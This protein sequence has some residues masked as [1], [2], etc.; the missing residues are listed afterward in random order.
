M[1]L[2]TFRLNFLIDV[3]IKTFPGKNT[4]TW[5]DILLCKYN[6]KSPIDTMETVC[7]HFCCTTK[8]TKSPKTQKRIP[9]TSLYKIYINI[10]IQPHIFSNKFFNFDSGHNSQAIDTK[11]DEKYIHKPS[12]S[13][14]FLYNI[15]N[16]HCNACNESFSKRSPCPYSM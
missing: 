7:E 14:I 8:T 16:F 3:N 6:L 9:N 2:F 1:L 11:Q 10:Y 5:N 15:Q 13:R 4:S 12:Q